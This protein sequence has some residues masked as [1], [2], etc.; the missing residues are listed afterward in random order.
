MSG[1]YQKLTEHLASLQSDEWRAPFDEIEAI[2]GIKLPQS[3]HTY[4]AWWSNQMRAQSLTWQSVGWKTADLDIKSGF[5][6]FVRQSSHGN[7]TGAPT[8]VAELAIA[9]RLSI[10]EAKAGLAAT[11]G[12]DPSQIDITIRA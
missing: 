1:K 11:F 4:P 7:E 3:A 9:P 6:T 5:V 10:A 2:I 8:P 12:V